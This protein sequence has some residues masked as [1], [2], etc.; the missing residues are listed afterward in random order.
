MSKSLSLYLQLALGLKGGLALVQS[1]L[2][3]QIGMRLASAVAMAFLVPTLGYLFLRNRI[4]KFDA[5]AIAAA[6]CSASA[7]TFATAMQDLESNGIRFGGH[8]AVA[9]V[10]M[11]SPAIIMAVLLANPCAKGAVPE[12]SPRPK[13]LPSSAARAE[14]VKH[15]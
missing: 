2:N 14:S 11:E 3:L 15:C 10:L 13:A 4:P 7:V 12:G 5:A 9:M 8:M 6:Y 1:D